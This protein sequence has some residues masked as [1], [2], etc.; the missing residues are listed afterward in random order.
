MTEKNPIIPENSAS[1]FLRIEQATVLHQGR[2]LFQ[3]L[4]FKIVNGESWVILG[5]SGKERTAFL[6]T[7]LGR[8]SLVAGS[9]SRPFAEDYQKEQ[10]QKGVVNSFRDLI[11]Y[12]SQ[13]YT[14]R[15]K[16]SQQNF[17]YQQRFNSSE[18]EDTETVARYLEQAETKIPGPWNLE[19][20][21][22]L[23][24]L[25]EF[26][27]KSLI[28]LSNGET[29]RLAL[30]LALLKNP[31]LFLMDMPMTGLDAPTRNHFDELVGAIMDSGIQVV[32]TCTAGEIPSCIS[33]YGWV[34]QGK[35]RVVDDP[36][37]L[38]E[39]EN[40]SLLQGEVP[41][42][43]FKGLLNN[44]YEH[45]SI[46][47]VIEMR[48]VTIRYQDNI[49]LDRVNWKVLPGERWLIRGHNGAGKSTLIS[50]VLGENPQSYANDIVLFDRKRG[51]GESIW[52][53]KKPVG[54]VS[55]ELG[56]FFPSN[57]TC[58]KVVLS[59]LFDTMGLF[60]KPDEIQEALADA[61]LEAFGLLHVADLNFHRIS[62]EEQRFC[63][64]A[65]AMIKTPQLL[66]LDEASQGMD[67][68]QRIRF[69]KSIS[70]FCENTGMSLIFVSHYDED[71]PACVNRIL[72]LKQGKIN[73]QTVKK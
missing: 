9:I 16:S 24:N 39:W 35:L 42:A 34:G 64:L 44:V 73:E 20:V 28:K 33:R 63:L 15:N 50:L 30:A 58:K 51:T 66:V 18:S 37:T 17:Y 19:N 59:G 11:A 5:A 4:D 52:D 26:K 71:V 23:V 53:I 32:M 8:T 36:Q 70:V 7:L 40:R 62:L 48:E 69:R 61:W 13:K 41:Q 29:R 3:Q 60:K 22:S 21:M 72:E 55:P 1:D 47:A 68:E 12:V 27:E 67:E 31:R 65:R 43:A 54:F 56:R 2:T 57:Q 46:S 38:M 14:F 6:E 49:L 10:N 45:S 25:H